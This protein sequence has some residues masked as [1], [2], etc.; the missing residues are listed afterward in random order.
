MAPELVV[1]ELSVFAV[2]LGTSP[3]DP[4]P[5]DAC[6]CRTW[7]WAEECAMDIAMCGENMSAGGYWTANGVCTRSTA[8]SSVLQHDG[9]AVAT[10]GETVASANMNA[11]T[12]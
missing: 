6:P 2:V 11:T 4:G 12:Q 7:R 1:A 10:A 9:N 3:A 5:D 8:E